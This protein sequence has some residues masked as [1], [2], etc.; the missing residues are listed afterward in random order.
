MVKASFGQYNIPQVTGYLTNFNPMAGATE[1]RTWT[2]ET[3]LNGVVVANAATLPG[4]KDGIPQ[5]NEIVAGSPSFGLPSSTPALDPNFKRE[6]AR[7]LSA[8][9]TRQLMPGYGISFNWFRRDAHNQA[10]I[11]NRAVDPVKDWTPF[12][13][14]NPLDGTSITAYNLTA[15][16]RARVSD[17]YQTNADPEKR[18]NIYTGFET[19]FT[20]KLPHRGHLMT[21]WTVDR[22]TDVTCDMPI[23]L[24]LI[25]LVQIHG[26]NSSNTTYNNPNSLRFCDERGKLPFRHELK[27]IATM[28]IKWGIEGSA[29]VQSSPEDFKYLNWDITSA[30]RYSADCV[31]CAAGTVIAPAA[32]TTGSER[33]ALAEPGTRYADRLNQVDL[34]LK[35]TFKFR[36][37]IRLQAQLDVFNVLNSSTVLVETVALGTTAKTATA[38]PASYSIAPFVTGGPGGRP[39]SILQARLMRLAVQLHF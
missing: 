32:I 20:G 33:I 17:L 38:A 25:G 29:I 23:G 3:R 34:G 39:T 10:L 37:K 24:S 19:S 31:G 14:T 26:S 12:T 21:A 35:K 22:V 5:D 4:Y 28:P 36:E 30:A 8:G 6:F 11:V 9:F 13:V 27:V 18:K 7:Q 16:A 2:D 15:A 1:S